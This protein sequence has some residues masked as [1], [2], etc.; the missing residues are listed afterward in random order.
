MIVQQNMSAAPPA[1]ATQLQR[2]F[3]LLEI[4]VV[5]VIFGIL[6][7][8]STLSIGSFDEDDA[9]EHARRF[10]ALIELALEEAGMQNRELGLHFY[11][12]GYE[13]SMRVTE[14]DEDGLP[15]WLWVPVDTDPIFKSRDLGENFALDVEI[16]SK[17]VTL[18]YER[19]EEETYTPQIYILSSGDIQPEFILRIRPAYATEGITLAVNEFGEVEESNDE[20]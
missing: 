4:L 17:E 15:I 10:T 12:H 7:S 11:Q 2:G 18:K 14:L 19:D 8:L 16:D 9:A 1:Q 5:V 3:T 6:I 13:F 20:F